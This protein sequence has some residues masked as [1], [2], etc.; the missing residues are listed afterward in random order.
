LL[1]DGASMLARA[2]DLNRA[3]VAAFVEVHPDDA[4]R[5]ALRDGSVAE[6]DFGEERVVRMPA[7]VSHA[8]VPG[9]AFIPSNQPNLALG[10]LLGAAPAL[11]VAL[12]AVE[13]VAA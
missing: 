9:C 8:V 2:A 7:R 1:L 12:R 10:E 3:T 4:E 13:E 6:V 5:L 11:R